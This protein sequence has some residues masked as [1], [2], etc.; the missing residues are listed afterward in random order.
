MSEPVIQVKDLRFYY[1]TEA[2]PVKAVDGV[3]F[4]LGRGSRLGLVGESGCG[5]STLAMAIIRLLK[6]PGRLVGGQILL[7]G[8]DLARLSEEEMR[9]VRLNG[10]SLIPQ[11]AMNSLN[12]VVKVRDQVLDG[13]QDHGV[14][15]TKEKAAARVEQLLNAV[16]L[17]PSVADMY[18][19][20]LSGGMKQRVCVAVA[21][22]ME[23]KVILADEPTSAL[24][25]VVQRQ[26]MGTIERLQ[27][28]MRISMILIGHDMG[29]MAQSVDHLAVMYSGRLAEIAGVEDIFAEPLHPY[30]RLLI[31]TLPTLGRKGEFQGI[32]GIPPSLLNPPPGCLFSPRCPEAMN[33]CSQVAPTWGEIRPGCWVACHLYEGEL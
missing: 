13:I 2:G 8:V 7:D 21:I 28:E 31:S 4:D 27:E 25:V 3:T 15:L 10:I 12:P 16:D 5:K 9:E 17:A 33:I 26:I 32:P 19:H 29:L 20:E 23:P 30:T 6:P 24:D 1:Y 22:S 14:K 11:G 18:P